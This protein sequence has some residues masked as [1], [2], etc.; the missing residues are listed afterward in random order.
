MS[1]LSF[2]NTDNFIRNMVT[3]ACDG[4]GFP[5]AV[6]V[7]K[8]V[9]DRDNPFPISIEAIAEDLR[10]DSEDDFANIKRL[11]LGAADFLERRT[12]YVLVPGEYELIV[13]QWWQGPIMIS[14]GPVRDLTSVSYRTGKSTYVEV[15]EANYFET[16]V[17]DREFAVSLL[18]T[19]DRPSLWTEQGEVRMKFTAG[20]QS[21]GDSSGIP[22]PDGLITAFIALIAHYYKN[23][24][25]FD[26]GKVEQVEM[27]AGNLLG[28][29]KM[30][31]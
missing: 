12:A 30:I 31:W 29:Y 26:A 18:S 17:N 22:A 5:R 13:G 20:F 4:A 15:D 23:R 14:R 7:S 16:Q 27:T 24:E 10:L 9:L 21:D 8:R 28:A 19:W 2:Q 6:P 3:I 1:A 25:L 11:G